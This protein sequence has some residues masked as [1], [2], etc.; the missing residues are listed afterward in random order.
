MEF[1]LVSVLLF[2]LLFGII[3]FGFALFKKNS[4]THAAREG[5]RIAAVGIASGSS[6][7][8]C[9]LFA[10][11]VIDRGRGANI[12]GVTVDFPEGNE[13]DAVVVVSVSYSVDLTLAGAFIPGIPDSLDLTETGEARIERKSTGDAEGGCS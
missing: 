3:G 8:N 7:P 11:E 5:A 9:M 1:A 4:A 10:E 6:Y 13:V 2:T 12:T